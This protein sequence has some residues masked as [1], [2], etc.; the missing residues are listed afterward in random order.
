MMRV[1]YRLILWLHPPAFRRRFGDQMLSIFEE[2]GMHEYGSATRLSSM[3]SHRWRASGYCAQTPGSSLP[4]WL[5]RSFRS[6]AAA[7]EH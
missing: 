1:L 5:E 4:P 7:C 2:E 3:A 6:G